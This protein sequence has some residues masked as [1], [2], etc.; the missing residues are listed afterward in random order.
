VTVAAPDW[1]GSA[2]AR[3]DDLRADTGLVF[4]P[5]DRV[6][7]ANRNA[8]VVPVL[9]A[10]HRA[11]LRGAWAFGYVGYEAAA[12]LD[13]SL[14]ISGPAGDINEP[15]VWFGLC[16]DG[17]TATRAVVAPAGTERRYVRDPWRAGWSRAGYRSAV[18]AIRSSI[19]AGEIYQC[20]LTVRLRSQISGELTQLYADL[21]A[22]QRGSHAAYLDLGATVIASASPELFFEWDGD[23]IRTRPMKGTA[24]R[25]RTPREDETRRQA[26]LRSVKERA[27]NIMIVDLLRND[28]GRI[29]QVGSVTVPRLC[30]AER[31]ESVWQLTSDIT[32]RVVEGTTLVDVFRA[33]FPSGSVTGA[34][35]QRAMLRISQLEAAPRGVYCGAI[36]YV[37]PPGAGVTRFSVAIRTVVV[38]RRSGAARYGTGGGITWASDPDAEH[39]ELLLKAAI[40]EPPYQPFAEFA[41]LETMACLPGAGPRN[42]DRHLARLADSARYFGFGFDADDALA[43]LASLAPVSAPTRVRLVLSRSGGLALSSSAAPPPPTGPVQLVVDCE[44]V[45]TRLPWLYHKTTRRQPYELRAARHPGAD[46]VILVNERDEVTETTIANLAVR[47]DGRWYTP[48]VESGCLPGVERGRLVDAGRLQE[49]AI[50]VAELWRAEA[51]AVVNSLRGWRPAT[52]RAEVTARV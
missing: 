37:A 13:A 45:D 2:W 20:N 30:A 8:D 15:M 44:P 10:V 1:P 51:V 26:L 33:L 9:A 6:L 32:A 29:A 38:D 47:I 21:A 52:L 50:T 3:F 31:Y 17:P 4:G 25:G 28:L 11:T 35:K 18:A 24:A 41:L 40:L 46:D 36:G 16:A 12:G 19:A 27:E 43:R 42:R 7:V 39:A 23:Q 34:P 5:P 49:R 48:P 14:P 22:A